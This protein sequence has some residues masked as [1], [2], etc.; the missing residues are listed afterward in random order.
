[1][2]RAKKSCV[3]CVH[4]HKCVTQTSAQFEVPK[5][6]LLDITRGDKLIIQGMV[7]DAI[8]E[9]CTNHKEQE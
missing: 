6:D 5:A 4:S 7:W 8:G 3:N 2:P 1:M 9:R